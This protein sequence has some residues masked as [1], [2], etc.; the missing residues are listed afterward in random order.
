MTT[1]KHIGGPINQDPD[2]RETIEIKIG[3]DSYRLKKW[4]G[5]YDSM[6]VDEGNN[7]NRVEIP[8]T[9]TA[10]STAMLTPDSGADKTVRLLLAWLHSWQYE[11]KNEAGETIEIKTVDVSESNVKSINI[12]HSVELTDEIVT[13]ESAM[14]SFRGESKATKK[15]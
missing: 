9:L 6:K 1:I 15:N 10:K 2:T 3:N 13:L 11:V 14:R 4:I 5:M 8:L 7:R 12:H